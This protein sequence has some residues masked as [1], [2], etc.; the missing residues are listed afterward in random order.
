MSTTSTTNSPKRSILDDAIQSLRTSTGLQAS[1]EVDESNVGKGIDGIAVISDGR[2]RWR[3]SLELKGQLNGHTLGSAIAAVSKYKRQH[4]PTALV[5]SYINPSQAEKLRDLGVE[6]F[7]TAGNVFLKQEGLHVF[8]TG[9][10]ARDSN[11]LESRPARAFNATGSR[12]IFALLCN[13]GLEERTY[14]QLA[15][16]A[17]ISLGAVNWII[18]DLKSLGYLIDNKQV[19]RIQNRKELLKRWVAAYP[20][21]LRP[22][23]LIGRYHKEDARKWWK[24]A[25]LPAE[26]FWGGEIGAA[27]ITR[28]L[29]PEAVTIYCETNLPKLQAQQA[30]RRD[31]NGETELLRRFWAFDK[32]DEQDKHVVPPLLIYA[33]LIRTANDRNL[34]TAE[35]LYDQCIARLVE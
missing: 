35:I 2:K 12:L 19:R 18:S 1:V 13:P 30:L 23:L 22:K 6:F 24:K 32:W 21:Q 33:D 34:E 27:L 15:T 4:G 26:A 10:K 25:E 5:T 8:V 3:F 20:E 14:R 9:R 16:E 11:K 31:S 17:G 28:H 29:S 7:D